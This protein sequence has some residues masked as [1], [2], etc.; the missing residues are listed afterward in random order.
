[1]PTNNQ[2]SSYLSY[3]R[4]ETIKCLSYLNCSVFWYKIPIARIRSELFLSFRCLLYQQL[5][6]VRAF[7]QRCTFLSVPLERCARQHVYRVSGMKE[8]FKEQASYALGSCVISKNYIILF[9]SFIHFIYSFFHI[10]CQ[11][12]TVIQGKQQ[13]T[14]TVN[15]H[16]WID[17]LCNLHP[18]TYQGVKAYTNLNQG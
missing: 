18:A 3:R 7:V 6:C 9:Y 14:S 4:R 8:G 12:C 16:E 5:C 2:Q 1:M 13:I 17:S 11:L 10:Q 15:V